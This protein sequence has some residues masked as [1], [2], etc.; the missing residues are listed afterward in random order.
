[1]DPRYILFAPRGGFAWSPLGSDK[2]V[3][4]GGFGWAYNRNGIADTVAAFENGLG[5]TVNL[6]QTSLATMAAASTAQR[7]T[8]RSIGARDEAGGAVPT[9]YDYSISVQRQLPYN[10]IADAA[11]IGNLQRHQ[12]I[13]FNLNSI[14][15][16]TAF[17]PEFVDPRSAGYNFAG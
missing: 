13:N 12:P 17:R 11:Y 5:N 14:P 3:F 1:P 2:T 4:R 9:I 16:G 6:V 10:L 8:P 7:L 15:L